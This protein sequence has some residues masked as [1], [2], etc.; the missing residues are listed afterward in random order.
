M[1]CTGSLPAWLY[2]MWHVQL[3]GF[4]GKVIF[5]GRY[6]GRHHYH[7]KWPQGAKPKYVDDA[8]EMWSLNLQVSS[9]SEQWESG[10]FKVEAWLKLTKTE[11]RTPGSFCMAMIALCDKVPFWYQL[12]LM[13][14]ASCAV[15]LSDQLSQWCNHGSLC[16]HVQP[17][18]W[19]LRGVGQGDSKQGS[20]PSKGS[21]WSQWSAQ[22]ATPGRECSVSNSR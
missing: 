7:L 21:Q 19:R 4:Q 16:Q 12:L 11:D 20:E 14:T 5:I 8:W 9:L 15:L 1:D 22:W 3:C 17:A 6:I 18:T 13:S 10:S 2:F